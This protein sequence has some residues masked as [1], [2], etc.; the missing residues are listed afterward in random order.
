M[1]PIGKAPLGS[2]PLKVFKN[3]TWF[4]KFVSVDSDGRRL[5]A[6]IIPAAFGHRA[7][8]FLQ[9]SQGGDTVGSTGGYQSMTDCRHIRHPVAAKN[10]KRPKT[11]DKRT[12]PN[13]HTTPWV[14]SD[15]IRFTFILYSS[16]FQS[17]TPFATDEKFT[18]MRNT[19]RPSFL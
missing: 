12:P 19:F 11:Q 17:S 15:S 3:R 6:F 8:K 10:S 7:E 18:P 2:L 4:L 13:Q 16:T 9:I 5:Q 14:F 1:Y